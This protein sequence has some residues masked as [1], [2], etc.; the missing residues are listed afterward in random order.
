M[1][2]K[3]QKYDNNQKSVSNKRSNN[4]ISNIKN[5]FSRNSDDRIK[6]SVSSQLKKVY[7]QQNVISPNI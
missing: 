1:I 6:N 7:S 3:S 5:S 2:K 4:S